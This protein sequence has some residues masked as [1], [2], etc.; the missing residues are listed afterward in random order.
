MLT[1]GYEMIFSASADKMVHKGFTFTNIF[2]E[3]HYTWSESECAYL[4]DEVDDCFIWLEDAEENVAT[5]SN[6]EWD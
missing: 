5:K 2:G 4:S 6:Y 1:I 3:H